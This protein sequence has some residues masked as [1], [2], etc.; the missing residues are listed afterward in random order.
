MFSSQLRHDVPYTGPNSRI[1]YSLHHGIQS[2]REDNFP[3][4][5]RAP[6]SP[7]TRVGLSWSFGDPR[8]LSDENNMFVRSYDS[9]AWIVPNLL[10][11]ENQRPKTK[12]KEVLPPVYGG[13]VSFMPEASLRFAEEIG[14]RDSGQSY[15]YAH[16]SVVWRGPIRAD[17]FGPL[18]HRS[19]SI[20]H[21]IDGK[22]ILTM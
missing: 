15:H 10:Q 1:R 7:K 4:I 21:P 14:Q 11:I 9:C 6:L 22:L 17:V 8:A 19:L 16:I 12:V 2:A 5:K 3:D 20:I 13:A 18:T